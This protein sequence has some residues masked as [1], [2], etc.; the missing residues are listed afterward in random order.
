MSSKACHTSSTPSSKEII[1]LVI[2][3]SVIGKLPSS[4]I[5]KKKGIT[6][7]VNP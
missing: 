5:D 1:N 4:L 2:L 6:E 7:P 3:S